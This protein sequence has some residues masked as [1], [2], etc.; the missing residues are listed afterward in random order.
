MCLGAWA[1]YKA[2]Q[3]QNEIV[4]TD[5]ELQCASIMEDSLSSKYIDKWNTWNG[6][7]IPN[8]IVDGVNEIMNQCY[9]KANTKQKKYLDKIYKKL[10]EEKPELR[11]T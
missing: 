7:E 6:N 3:N 10:L 8:Q 4:M 2:R 5:N 9:G 1:L 11:T